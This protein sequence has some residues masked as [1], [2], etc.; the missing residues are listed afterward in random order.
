KDKQDKLPA[1]FEQMEP[2]LLFSADVEGTHATDQQPSP[3]DAYQQ[4]VLQQSLDSDREVT[5]ETPAAQVRIELIFVDTDTPEYQTLLSDLLTYP[6]D[7]T[8]YQVFELDNT[9]D[10]IA[11]ITDILGGFENVNAIH[12]LSHGTEGSIDLGGGTLDTDTLAANA[13][14]IGSWGSAF[15]ADADIL[16]YGCNLAANEAGQSLVNRLAGLTGADVAASEDL[17]GSAELGGDWEL[18]YT[19]GKLE[20]GIFINRSAAEAWQNT[21]DSAPTDLSS[22]IA[23]NTDSGNDSYLVSS[24]GLP[25]SLDST[26]VEISFAANNIPLETVFMSFNNPA[27]DEFTLQNQT[28]GSLQIDFGG[29]AVAIAA[30]MDFRTL[31][32]GDLH[33]L[34]VSW[35]NTNGDWAV[36]AD[37]NF[38]E[39][40]TGLST[41]VALDTTNG[42]FV[43]GQEQDSLLGGFDSDQYFSG[44]L[45]D[46]RLWSEVRSA[47]EIANNY[48]HKFDSGSLPAGLIAN[49]QMDGFN[50]SN[51]VV[52]V[53]GANNLS[54][55]HAGAGFTA[56]TPDATLSV[57]ENAFNGTPVGIVVPTDPDVYNDIVSDG[58]FTEAGSAAGNPTY[59]ANGSGAGSVLG[60]WT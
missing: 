47:E 15:S 57:D 26:T 37:G 56:S 38:V 46:V 10:G 51:E 40:G 41:G 36:Y 11:Q 9:R 55:A 8:R 29:G 7:A 27:G 30:T 1:L 4:T 25:Q 12:I 33:S 21:L 44:T 54:I 19:V 52:D 28:D 20:T 18:E 34:A 60:D 14:L 13:E 59:S 43:F 2:R 31:L 53:V 16:I 5:R 3:T 58:L 35:D 39:S 42:Q 48:Q 49:W 17:T 23:L 6:D 22:G 50:G 32:D 24:T 45:H